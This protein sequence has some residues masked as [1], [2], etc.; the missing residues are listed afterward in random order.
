MN[1][2]LWWTKFVFPSKRLSPQYEIIRLQWTPVRM[3]LGYSE[4][5][6]WIILPCN[7]G[8]RSVILIVIYIS[9]FYHLRFM[10]LIF[11]SIADLFID[12][13]DPDCCESTKCHDVCK[14][15][16]ELVPRHQSFLPTSSFY[17]RIQFLLN[18]GK[19]QTR[20]NP[21][22]INPRYISCN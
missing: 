8:L 16:F 21:D 18:N 5:L 3:N 2:R 19:T 4:P 20:M 10:A 6:L 7:W 11:W 17:Q 9:Q 13:F 12:C 22:Y 1:F 15:D 14:S